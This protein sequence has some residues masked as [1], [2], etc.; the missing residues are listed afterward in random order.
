[1]KK[2]SRKSEERSM[3]SDY[4]F[5][6][7]IRGKYARRYAKGANVVL[8]EPD[9]AKV[10]PTSKVVNSSLQKIIRQR[11]LEPPGNRLSGR[12]A[13]LAGRSPATAGRRLPAH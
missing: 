5:S 7:A 4:D 10:F 1:M 6:Q 11:S 8:L 2:K 13:S 3:K 12:P 9:V